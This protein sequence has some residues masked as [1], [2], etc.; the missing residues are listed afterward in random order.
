MKMT[1]EQIQE[2]LDGEIPEIKDDGV[3]CVT[4]KDIKNIGAHMAE[5]A[6]T[7]ERLREQLSAMAAQHQCGC[8]HPACNRCRDDADNREVLR[9]TSSQL[10]E[11]GHE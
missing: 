4:V 1:N 9:A 5:M 7:V 3:I 10:R 2:I 11:K 8:G 6:V